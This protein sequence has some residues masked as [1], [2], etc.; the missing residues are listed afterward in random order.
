MIGFAWMVLKIYKFRIFIYSAGEKNST[1]E[2]KI[3]G[4]P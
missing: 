3:G 2:A 4:N 1:T